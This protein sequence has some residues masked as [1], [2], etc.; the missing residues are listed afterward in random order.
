MAA[1]KSKKEKRK[2]HSQQLQENS[3]N[4]TEDVNTFSFKPVNESKSEIPK[5]EIGKEKSCKE[6]EK[7]GK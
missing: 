2:N 6:L 1:K 3:N 5:I 4:S 7:R